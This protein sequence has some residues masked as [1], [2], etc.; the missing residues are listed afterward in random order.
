MVPC[1]LLLAIAVA[2]AASPAKHAHKAQAPSGGG[3]PEGMLAAMHGVQAGRIRADVKLL[4]SDAMEGRGTGAHGGELAAAYVAEQFKAAGLEPAGDN[5]SY[6]Q[7]VPLV[8]ETTLSETSLQLK[9]PKSLRT[10]REF[11][12]A[13]I[14]NL[15]HRE[16]A[17]VRSELVFVGYGITAPEFGWDDYA[18]V[19]V[20]G[21]V[22]LILVNEPPSD[23]PRFFGG[24]ALTYYGRWT[25]KFEQAA[26]MG[27]AGVLLIHK[28]EMASYGWEVVRS[29][30]S[31]ERS[32][33][34][35]DPDSKLAMAAWVQWESA[36]ALLADCG[37]K[38]DELVEL[39]GKRGFRAMPLPV[40]VTAHVASAVRHFE[41][42]NVIGKLTGS[43][44]ELKQQGIFFTGHYD[45]L[46]MRQK[47]G[48]P[49]SIYHGALDNATGTA[50]V[51]E[52]ARA[53]AAAS[54]RPRRSVYF[55]ATTAEEQGLWGSA[56]LVRHPPVPLSRISLDVN[57][58]A[59]KPLGIP[60]EIEADGMERT[61]IAALFEHT[62]ADFKMTVRAPRHPED[63]GYFRSDHF[64]FAMQGVPAFSVEPGERF[65]GH[66]EAWVKT[67]SEEMD[68]SYHQPSD[69]YKDEYDYRTDA[70]LA[71]FGVALA[72]RVGALRD[73][74]Q[75]KS[76]DEFERLR[77]AE[78]E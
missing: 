3:I 68:H 23:D 52:M 37:M 8:G 62:A 33:L 36:N 25:Y 10:L 28:T 13:M 67:K 44:A 49:P 74:V 39:A 5:G 7:R 66:I 29:S 1:F 72:Y 14:F 34:A 17:D 38:I 46:G 12:D 2:G 75:W 41:S 6:L 32:S 70:I 65:S 42:S 30:W 53:M 27:A 56:Y 35:D 9:T 64:S 51:I 20:K 58:D 47:D 31:G 21:K 26:R 61:S 59:I 19:D 69:E 63:G 50:I 22:L 76:G 57:F 18:G 71:R 15:D 24:K 11:D 4:S 73:L 54:A 48:E 43:D 77:K 16:K 45:H 60:Q 78:A 55:V 40:S